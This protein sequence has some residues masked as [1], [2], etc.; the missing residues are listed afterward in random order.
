MRPLT[1][2]DEYY[3]RT[4]VDETQLFPVPI[5]PC[6]VFFVFIRLNRPEVIFP[7]LSRPEP[8]MA[9]IPRL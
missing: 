9:S 7:A 2:E 4:V 6:I 3:Q 5:F 1:V 8:A